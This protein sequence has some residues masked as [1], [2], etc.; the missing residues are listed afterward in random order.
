MRE[1]DGISV[2]L[3]LCLSFLFPGCATIGPP[4]APSLELPKPP[5]DLRAR[6]KG[7]RVIL[8][9][10]V[11]TVTTDRQRVRGLGPTRICRSSD[12]AATQCLPVGE[13]AP[14]AESAA[15]GNAAGQKITNT[16]TDTLPTRAE[17]EPF[18]SIYYAVEVLNSNGRGAGLSKPVAVMLA[19]A[20]PPP[21]DFSAR[22]SDQGVVLTWTGELLSLPYPQVV[23][24][25]YRVYRR[26][27][28]SQQEVLVGQVEVGSEAR[29][30]LTD[31]SFE[32][33]RTYYY[34]ADTLTIVAQAGKAEIQIE[35][36]DSAEVK[37][38][39]DDVFP[40]AVPSGLQAVFSGPGQQAFIDLIWTPVTDMDLAGYNVYRREE[41]AAAVK[42][43]VELVKAP[44]Y[45]DL[46]VGSGRKYSY[47]VSAVDVRG[48]ESARSEEGSESVP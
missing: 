8:T 18:G 13:A 31:Q 5:V 48:N 35:G 42:V 15:A 47:S 30:S 27:E 20:L 43:N 33:G 37:V 25:L 26:L 14:L 3:C 19:E 11:P 46:S 4:Q 45:R 28:G 24:H 39:A 41:G 44:A 7:D 2:V 1:R 12:P 38:F 23:R 16:Y 34:H 32:W 17:R 36:D 29:P 6:R 21:R 22:V 9:W 40:P 10:T